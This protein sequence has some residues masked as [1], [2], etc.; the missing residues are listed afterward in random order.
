[1]KLH[2]TKGIKIDEFIYAR[3]TKVPNGFIYVYIFGKYDENDKFHFSADSHKSVVF[4]PSNTKT[5]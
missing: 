3:V 4:V 1:M 2:E 5:K